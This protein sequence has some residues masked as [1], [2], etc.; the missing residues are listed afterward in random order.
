MRWMK[1]PRWVQRRDIRSLRSRI[2]IE[3][4]VS[5]KALLLILSLDNN[6]H[7]V[8]RLKAKNK[9]KH[10]PNPAIR[11]SLYSL[12]AVHQVPHKLAAFS[13]FGHLRRGE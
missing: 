7:C 10:S 12:Y 8:K 2:L 4:G 5:G 3:L 1:W 11:A 13:F 9:T 6:F